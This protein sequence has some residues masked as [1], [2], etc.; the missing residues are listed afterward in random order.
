V[1]DLDEL[2]STVLSA[3]QDAVNGSEWAPPAGGVITEAVIVMH[4]MDPDGTTGMSFVPATNHFWSTE[5]LLRGALRSHLA[6]P[7]DDDEDG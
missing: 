3:L 5:G 1:T 4:W 2:R 6:P 7:D